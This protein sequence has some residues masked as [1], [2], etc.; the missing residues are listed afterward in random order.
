M[1][2][3]GPLG[4]RFPCVPCQRRKVLMFRTLGALYPCTRYKRQDT[5]EFYFPATFS[6]GR[7]CS[8]SGSG[9]RQ[10]M[11]TLGPRGPAFPGTP[12]AHL[13][14]PGS[15]I[16]LHPLREA[17]DCSFS[18]FGSLMSR[19]PLLQEAK[20]HFRFPG[21]QFPSHPLQEADHANSRVHGAP[22]PGIHCSR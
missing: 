6:R 5:S 2:I 19:R 1:L 22:F 14:A 20:A 7:S 13:H 10:T 17:R 11:L 18:D 4:S 12:R 15:H 21:A 3:F 9:K 16:S 8:S